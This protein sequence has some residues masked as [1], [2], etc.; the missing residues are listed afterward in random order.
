MTA[1]FA[2]LFGHYRKYVFSEVFDLKPTSGS[3]K[4]PGTFVHASTC[5]KRLAQKA[6]RS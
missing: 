1:L 3:L 6:R 5:P 4:K 2:E